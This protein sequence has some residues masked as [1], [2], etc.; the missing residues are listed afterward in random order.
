MIE[1][2]TK[3]PWGALRD[4]LVDR[5]GTLW[6]ASLKTIAFLE[7]GS[8][9]FAPT[10]VAGKDVTTLGQAPNGRVWMADYNGVLRPVPIPGRNSAEDP[11]V[12]L[13]NPLGIIPLGFHGLPPV[14]RSCIC[15]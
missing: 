12:V 7:P 13:N 14:I 10:G 11:A 9:P 2:E 3:F 1:I 5:E 6:V 4:I 15:P 8:E